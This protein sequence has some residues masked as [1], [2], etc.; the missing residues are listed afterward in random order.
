MQRL[1]VSITRQDLKAENFEKNLVQLV[2]N[3][4]EVKKE[5][6]YTNLVEL[7]ITLLNENTAA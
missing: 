2:P 6:D 5:V 1:K 3:L 4:E 7:M